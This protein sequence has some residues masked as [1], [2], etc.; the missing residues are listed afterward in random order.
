MSKRHRPRTPRMADEMRR[1]IA[2]DYLSN[3]LTRSQTAEKYGL[4]TPAVISQWVRKFGLSE[5]NLSLPDESILTTMAKKH[6]I[7][8]LTEQEARERIRQLEAEL[9][10]AKMQVLA[11]NTMID[12]AEEQGYPIRKKSG[13]KQ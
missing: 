8:T 11:L 3:D 5:K 10:I 7:E 4:P 9:G 1:E 13:A 2:M 6:E 12:I